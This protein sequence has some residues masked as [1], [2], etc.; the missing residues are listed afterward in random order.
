MSTESFLAASTKPQVFTTTVSASSGFSTSRKPS[1]SNR[2]ASSSESTSL[3]AQPR[4]TRATDIGPSGRMGEVVVMID[5]SMPAQAEHM[6]IATP[7][8]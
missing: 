4:V 6:R 1:A 5:L 8:G 3:R 7:R 2:P